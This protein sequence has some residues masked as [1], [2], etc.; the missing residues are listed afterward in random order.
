MYALPTF[1]VRRIGL[2]GVDLAHNGDCSQLVHLW[3]EAACSRYPL[4]PALP[5]YAVSVQLDPWTRQLNRAS[6]VWV[7]LDSVTWRTRV[8]S[9]RREMRL[10]HYERVACEPAETGF[11]ITEAWRAGGDEIR[12]YGG[13]DSMPRPSGARYYVADVVLVPHDLPGCGLPPPRELHLERVPQ[14]LQEWIASQIRQ[15][16]W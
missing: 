1:A 14:L 2:D 15:Q 8:D 6:R 10:A 9:V 11:S 4:D 12:L 3:R 13:A 16:D 7:T 5:S